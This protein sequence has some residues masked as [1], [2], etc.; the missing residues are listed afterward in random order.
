MEADSVSMAE[1]LDVGRSESRRLCDNLSRR[2]TFEIHLR[3]RLGIRS[4]E[5]YIAT[6]Y[7]VLEHGIGYSTD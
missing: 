7:L 1:D 5:V 6:Q 2:T 3:D 4:G